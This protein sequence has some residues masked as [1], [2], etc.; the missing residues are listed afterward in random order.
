M[1]VTEVLARYEFGGSHSPDWGGFCTT[2]EEAQQ[3]CQARA[4]G[5]LR[6]T[7]VEGFCWGAVDPETRTVFEIG[8]RHSGLAEDEDEAS[9]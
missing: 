9:S 7:A 1:S 6:S 5:A 2:I 8:Q 3:E 4:C